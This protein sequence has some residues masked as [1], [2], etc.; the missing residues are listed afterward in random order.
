LFV[1]WY[2]QDEVDTLVNAFVSAGAAMRE[3]KCRKAFI[4]HTGM[5]PAMLPMLGRVAIVFPNPWLEGDAV[6]GECICIPLRVSLNSSRIHSLGPAVG[7]SV[8]IHEIAHVASCEEILAGKV[9]AQQAE[10]RAEAVETACAWDGKSPPKK[11]EQY[12]Y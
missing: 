7:A 8:L 6:L 4:K 11:I 2:D 3:D 12:K 5:D 1:H 10:A 9:N